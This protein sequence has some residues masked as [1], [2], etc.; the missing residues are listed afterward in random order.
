MK[1]HQASRLG[2]LIARARQARGL[3]YEALAR[4]TGFNH[5]WLH[6][7][8]HGRIID[9][10]PDR[11]ARLAELLDI[12]VARI[13]RMTGDHVSRSLPGPRVYYRSRDKLSPAALDELETAVARILRKHER[14]SSGQNAGG[15]S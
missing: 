12:D 8:E 2:T 1:Q 13:D 11:V 7:L 4:E 14:R 10:A 15:T 3:S 9:P 6:K 5:A